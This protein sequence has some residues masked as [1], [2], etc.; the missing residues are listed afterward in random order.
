MNSSEDRT[1]FLEGLVEETALKLGEHFTAVKI[2]A[3]WEDEGN[4]MRAVGSSGNHYAGIG[5]I[6]AYRERAIAIEQHNAFADCEA[7]AD[8]G[9]DDLSE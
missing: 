4:T 3:T 2:L 9:P 8:G 7:P 1:R 6:H 5:M